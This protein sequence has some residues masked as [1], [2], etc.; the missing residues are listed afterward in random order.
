MT[1]AAAPPLPPELAI[2]NARV[3]TGDPRRPWAD[4]LLVRDGAVDS[5]GSSAEV[6]KR[7][8]EGAVIIDARRMLV[9][10][11]AAT[12]STAG[13]IAPGAPAN[14]VLLRV[15]VPRVTLETVRASAVALEI[16]EGRIVHDPDGLAR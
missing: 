11:S 9:T 4:A 8:R 10:C 7:L 15:D 13:A 3:R 2:V 12:W 1:S 16:A 14:V 6:R 5:V